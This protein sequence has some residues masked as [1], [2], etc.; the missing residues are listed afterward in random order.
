MDL[1]AR[2]KETA[3]GLSALCRALTR[4]EAEALDLFQETWKRALERIGAYRDDLSF[5]GW[6]ASIARNLWLDQYRRRKVER[7]A[8]EGR[9]VPGDVQGGP[10]DPLEGLP[11]DEREAVALYH[12]Q[13]LSLKETA[14]ILGATVWDV[15]GRLRRAHEA[16]G[17]DS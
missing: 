2:Y 14:S 17:R 10:D 1:D 13:G 15:R 11:E 12:L 5:G 3:P 4:N 8:L 6:L 7:K 9:P 16:L